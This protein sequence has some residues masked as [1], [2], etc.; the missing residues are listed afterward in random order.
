M[1]FLLSPTTKKDILPIWDASIMTCV[2]G[3]LELVQVI[4]KIR[5][6]FFYQNS[7]ILI[8][9]MVFVFV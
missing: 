4:L 2:E 1:T 6:L 7:S 5:G 9:K 3:Q 8:V